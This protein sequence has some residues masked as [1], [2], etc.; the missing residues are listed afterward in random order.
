MKYD[1]GHRSQD[2]D[3]L[4]GQGPGAGGGGPIRGA[5]KLGIGGFVVV[6]LLSL[7]LKKN[8]F[9]YF[10][11]GGGGGGA[12]H[13][14]AGPRQGSPEE[15]RLV[16][17]VSFALDDIQNAWTQILPRTGTQYERA[18]MVLFTNTVRSGC[19]MAE[20]A[21]GPFYCP[22]DHKLYIDLGF[23]EELRTRFGAPGDFAQAYVIAHEVGHHVQNILG[24]EQRIRVMQRRDPSQ[25]NHLS[26]RME[27]Q[28]DCYAGVWAHSTQ[29][30]NLLD[31]GDLE[32]GLQGASSVG[33][34]RIQRSAGQRV[35][36]E[37]WTH[38][39]ARQRAAWFRKGYAT[40]D[41]AQCD[42]FNMPD[43]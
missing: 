6:G 2:V 24:T 34:D 36:P 32:E 26:I 18:R 16:S 21:M 27:L 39:S 37:S 20:A 3:D 13:T 4:R 33:D 7:V 17:F 41:V 40:G 35:N 15:Q 43:P 12:P 31:P 5:G 22:A 23:Y 8:L 19:G 25:E 14:S 38:G 1:E 11:G 30:R 28:A 10:Q 29:Q 42:T 9:V